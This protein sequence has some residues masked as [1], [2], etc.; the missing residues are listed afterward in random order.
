M[1]SK[2][3]S[4]HRR[5]ALFSCGSHSGERVNI[6]CVFSGANYLPCQQEVLEL[7]GFYAWLKLF[8]PFLLFTH[9][10]ALIPSNTGTAWEMRVASGGGGGGY[11]KRTDGRGEWKTSGRVCEIARPPPADA[12]EGRAL[13]TAWPI[14]WSNGGPSVRNKGPC[15]VL[16]RLLW[17]LADVCP[18]PM[19]SIKSSIRQAALTA[20]RRASAGNTHS[21][22]RSPIYCHGCLFCF[23]SPVSLLSSFHFSFLLF[24]ARCQASKSNFILP[25]PSHSACTNYHCLVLSGASKFLNVRK[26]F[27]GGQGALKKKSLMHLKRHPRN[28]LPFSFLFFFLNEKWEI[29]AGLFVRERYLMKIRS[30]TTS[31]WNSQSHICLPG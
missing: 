19:E 16:H 21:D 6:G 14:I 10:A 30:K 18:T 22:A 13:S 15:V 26:D 25:V 8:L 31:W 5:T 1:N 27:W 11:I 7:R 29:A 28:L 17:W 12:A 2:S 23:F 20:W 9:C 24:K 3:S 4:H